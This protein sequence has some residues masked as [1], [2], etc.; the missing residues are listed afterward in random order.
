[1][2]SVGWNEQ[3][4]DNRAQMSQ[5]WLMKLFEYVLQNDS[6]QT[7]AGIVFL[8]TLPASKVFDFAQQVAAKSQIV[9]LVPDY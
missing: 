6:F 2:M 5:C 1:M 4:S 9:S 8:L 3:L 7:F